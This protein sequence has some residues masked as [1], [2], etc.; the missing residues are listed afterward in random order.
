MLMR[1]S[2]ALMHTAVHGQ[3]EVIIFNLIKSFAR[4]DGVHFYGFYYI[5]ICIANTLY[6]MHYFYL[7]YLIIVYFFL[8]GP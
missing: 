6:T 2:N 7:S 4:D 1:N 3:P 8:C 5:R